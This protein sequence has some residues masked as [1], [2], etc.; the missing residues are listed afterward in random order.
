MKLKEHKVRV[1]LNNKEYFFMNIKALN[2]HDAQILLNKM[3]AVHYNGPKNRIKLVCGGKLWKIRVSPEI[4][5]QLYYSL[6][7]VHHGAGS[8]SN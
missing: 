3:W 2:K 6:K 5:R 8:A 4:E 1:E 7:E